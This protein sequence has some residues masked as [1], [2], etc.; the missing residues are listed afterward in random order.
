MK[1]VK[2]DSF[3]KHL[4]EAL[5][6]HPSDIYFVLMEDPFERGFIAER[7][8]KKL[9]LDVI[10][11]ES[12]NLLEELESPSLFSEKQILICDEVKEKEIP[13]IDDLILIF[14]GKTTPPF[15][16]KME[17]DGIILDLLQEKPWDRKSRL[18]RWLLECARDRGKALSIDGATYLIDFSH[19][20][21]ATLLQELDKI[22]AYSGE[23]KSLTLEMVK[24]ICFLDSVQS[25]WQLSEAV[26]LGGFVY[27]G[28]TDLYA[29]VGQLRYQ[30]QL[31]LQIAMAK[32][33]PKASL[34]KVERFRRSGLKPS[35]FIE[36]L[37]ELFNLEMKMRSNI[38]NQKL[39]FDQ[40]R[41]KLAARR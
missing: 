11:C 7:I 9:G 22:V 31:G 14:T 24:E 1:Y 39:L 2:I 10:H 25:G 6:D 3:E 19:A 36:G 28:E 4:D 13:K 29:L 18:Q 26:V 8:S 33:P 34:K 23:E 40:F 21:F 38:S 37:K 35:Y 15:Y 17:K 5:P 27:F 32:E 41:A 16:K 12:D 20:D 30:L